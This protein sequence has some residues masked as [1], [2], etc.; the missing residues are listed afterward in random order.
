MSSYLR[1]HGR[2]AANTLILW[3]AGKF[4]SRLKLNI[5]RQTAPVKAPQAEAHFKTTVFF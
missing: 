1:R 2:L 4:T 3:F 5:A